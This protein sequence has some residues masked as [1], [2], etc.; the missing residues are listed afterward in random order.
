MKKNN[1]VKYT[2]IIMISFSILYLMSINKNCQ[3]DVPDIEVSQQWDSQD[4]FPIL[5]E[6]YLFSIDM[7]PVHPSKKGYILTEG[8][9]IVFSKIDNQGLWKKYVLVVK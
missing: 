3:L 2:F 1:L 7:E 8:K 5:D 9:Y 4:V 6:Q